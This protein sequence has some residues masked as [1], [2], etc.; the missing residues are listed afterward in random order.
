MEG[1]ELSCYNMEWNYNPFLSFSNGFPIVFGQ[2]W[3]E[4]KTCYPSLMLIRRKYDICKSSLKRNNNTSSLYHQIVSD[5]N[6]DW[7]IEWAIFIYL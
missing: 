4:N 1:Y 6:L 2:E 7:Y 5:T 3:Y